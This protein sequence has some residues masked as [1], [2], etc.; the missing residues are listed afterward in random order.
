MNYYSAVEKWALAGRLHLWRYTKTKRGGGMEG[1]HLNADKE[2]CE[3]IVSLVDAML[4]VPAPVSKRIPVTTPNTMRVNP[5]FPWE[6]APA[7]TLRLM[8]DATPE[9]FWNMELTDSRLALSVGRAKLIEFQKSV[10]GLPSWKDDFAIG[11]TFDGKSKEARARF[12][13]MQIWF[14]TKI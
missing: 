8:D 11:P 14:W 1:W 9:D 13:E 7:L 3:S 5:G 10:A 12:Y 2:A 6:S 4:A